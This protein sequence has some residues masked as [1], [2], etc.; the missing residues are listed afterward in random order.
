MR[1]IMKK[2]WSKEDQLS[3]EVEKMR[4]ETRGLRIAE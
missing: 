2:R 1:E 3:E 4:E